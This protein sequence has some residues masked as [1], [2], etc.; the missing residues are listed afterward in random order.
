MLPRLWKTSR[1]IVLLETYELRLV[2]QD[3]RR[4]QTFY[5]QGYGKHFLLLCSYILETCELTVALKYG[6][7]QQTFYYQGNGKHLVAHG[8]I[9]QQSVCRYRRKKKPDN[10]VSLATT[11]RLN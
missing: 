11:P 8:K 10:V 4:Q 5:Y 1:I 7:R 2:L 9:P 3:G 6:R